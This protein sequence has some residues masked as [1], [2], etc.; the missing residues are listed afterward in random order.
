MQHI[1]RSKEK[2]HMIISTHAE[3]TL[4]K[5]QSPFWIRALMKLGTEEMHINLYDK[6]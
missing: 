6:L 2:N 4:G 3:R 5:I 1:K